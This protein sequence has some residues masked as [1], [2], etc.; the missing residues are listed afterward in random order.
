MTGRTRHTVR[1]LALVLLCGATVACGVQPSGVIEGA[2]PPSGRLDTDDSVTLYLVSDGE[3]SRVHRDDGPQSRAAVLALLADGPTDSER[4]R[5]LSSAVPSDAAP[6]TVTSHG[7]G[8]IEVE[9][10]RPPDQMSETAVNQIVCT[11][12]AT[13]HREHPRVEL[14]GRGASPHR[15]PIESDAAL[16]TEGVC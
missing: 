7:N 2:S 15:S 4:A 12:A 3:L 13:T 5:G 1:L 14:G 16:P 6:F 8:R 10:S 11:A 9:P